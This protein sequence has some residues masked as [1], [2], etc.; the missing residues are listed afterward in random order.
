MR[1]QIGH[2]LRLA[3]H[4]S[5]YRERATRDRPQR[6][7]RSPRRR[8]RGGVGTSGEPN[9]NARLAKLA[10]L[11]LIGFAGACAVRL[12]GGGP[13]TFRT[14]AY[15]APGGESAEATAAQIDATAPDIVLLTGDGDSTWFADVAQR[16]QL[17]L[18]GPGGTGET[19]QAFLTRGL[20][21]LG[22]TSIIL[23]VAS[24]G[25][26]HMHD[27]LYEISER[28]HIDLMLVQ[29]DTNDLREAMRT[30]LSYIA[31]DVGATAAVVFALDAATP[32]AADSAATLLRAA[33]TNAGECADATAM[34]IGETRAEPESEIALRLFYGPEVRTDC[35][36][37]TVLA[38]PGNPVVA[39]LV[40]R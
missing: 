13:R 37:A 38:A 6:A 15:S 1:K 20:E 31:T 12:G 16:T 5:G 10:L 4:G 25:R 32:Q 14:L 11:L 17:A 35:E 3:V 22:D 24:G 2:A 30:L 29:L 21:I 27:A 33:Y 39:D 36:Q 7:T 28:R 9:R 23:D 34:A 40:V 26:I 18:S 8:R 19:R